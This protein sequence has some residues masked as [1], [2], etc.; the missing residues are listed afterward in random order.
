MFKT[1]HDICIHPQAMLSSLQCTHIFQNARRGVYF[2]TPGAYGPLGGPLHVC[3]VRFNPS[4]SS[5]L[6]KGSK[7]GPVNS[8]K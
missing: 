7:V 6:C 4:K 1:Y 5:W 8:F 3:E 2:R